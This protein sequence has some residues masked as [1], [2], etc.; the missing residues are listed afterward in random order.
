MNVSAL[1]GAGTMLGYIDKQTL[2]ASVVSQTLDNLNNS[3]SSMSSMATTPSEFNASLVT[4]TLDTLNSGFNPG[5]SDAMSQTYDLS[6]D[7][8]GAYMTGKGVFANSSV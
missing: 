3:S 7:V 4:Q 1:A 5:S 2:G 8:L 6:K